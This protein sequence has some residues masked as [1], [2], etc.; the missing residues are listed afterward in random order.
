M[1]LGSDKEHTKA[2]INLTKEGGELHGKAWPVFLIQHALKGACGPVH[3]WYLKV[4]DD[5]VCITDLNALWTQPYIPLLNIITKEVL[6]R[7]VGLC[8]GGQCGS[9]AG[10][11]DSV[12]LLLPTIAGQAQFFHFQRRS[13]GAR[14]QNSSCTS[15]WS[16]ASGPGCTTHGEPTLR[17]TC[18]I[19]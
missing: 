13:S 3:N 5:V 11:F 15:S 7:K 4:G 1:V 16:I 2:L 12:A 8:G 14:S 17:S 6:I 18:K 9:L 10:H 19:A